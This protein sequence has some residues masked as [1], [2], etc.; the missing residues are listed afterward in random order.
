MNMD[1][2]ATKTPI[3]VN[4]EGAFGK[5]ILQTFILALM[6]NGTESRWKNWFW[7]LKMSW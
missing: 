2:G 5:R 7:W 4:K 6:V 1:F 3:K